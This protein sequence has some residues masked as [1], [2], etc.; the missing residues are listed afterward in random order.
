M[1]SRVRRYRWPEISR[2][3]TTKPW[4]LSKSGGYRAITFYSGKDVPKFGKPT[5]ERV[6]FDRVFLG[7]HGEGP[8][9]R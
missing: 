3:L 2:V 5:S 6:R 4:R 1:P 9:I 7:K 8:A